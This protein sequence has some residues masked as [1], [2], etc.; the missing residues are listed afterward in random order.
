MGPCIKF[1]PEVFLNLRPS[2]GNLACTASLKMLPLDADLAALV[3]HLEPQVTAKLALVSIVVE[4]VISKRRRREGESGLGEHIQ[5]GIYRV[6]CNPLA[7]TRKGA[8]V[9]WRPE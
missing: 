2:N 8:V 4:A 9:S 6:D 7:H 3:P 5:S 1:W